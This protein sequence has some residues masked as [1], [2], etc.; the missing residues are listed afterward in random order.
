M[1]TFLQDIREIGHTPKLSDYHWV[2]FQLAAAGHATAATSGT[3]T[4]GLLGPA[5]HSLPA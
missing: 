4:R 2:L 3:Q 5:E 1:R